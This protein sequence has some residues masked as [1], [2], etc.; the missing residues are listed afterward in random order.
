MK[1]LLIRRTSA[2]RTYPSASRDPRA[3]HFWRIF[4]YWC[5][6]NVV[7]HEAIGRLYLEPNGNFDEV[8][9]PNIPLAEIEDYQRR[10]DALHDSFVCDIES[11]ESDLPHYYQ[12]RCAIPSHVIPT[13]IPYPIDRER[14]TY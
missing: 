7:A 14:T 1:P 13:P 4:R 11:S 10:F 2:D 9:T 3:T 12:L 5:D 8:G 6:I